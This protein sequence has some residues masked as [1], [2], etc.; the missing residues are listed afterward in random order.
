M[1]HV[2]H[3]VV[4]VGASMGGLRTAEALRRNGYEGPIEI[5]GAEI[6]E[7]YN[8]PPLSKEV[9]ASTVS[10]S[11]VNFTHNLL[12]ANTQWTLGTKVVN[13]DPVRHTVTDEFGAEHKY[14]ALVIATGLRPRRL[15]LDG[16]NA[17]GTHVLRTLDDAMALRK[18]LVP[19]A[20]VVIVGAGFIGCEVASTALALGCKV[21]VVAAD[22][23]PMIRPLGEKFAAELQRRHEA[24]GV[25]YFL[26]NGISEIVT[27]EGESELRV[28]GL[29]LNNGQTLDCQVLVQAIGSYPNTEW[30]A[31]SDLDISDG[32][33]TDNAM[34]ALNT[35]GEVVPDVYAVGDVARFPNPR[36]N[37]VP[38]RIEHWNIP[39]ETAK[40]VGQVLAAQLS[41]Q[42]TF[43]ERVA[44][45]FTPLPSFW[46][47][48]FGMNLLAFGD[49]GLANRSQL[50]DGEVTGDCIWGYFK[51]DVLVGVCGIGM[52]GALQSYRK[53]FLSE[54]PAGLTSGQI[55]S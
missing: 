31:E 28:T 12:D 20:E 47:D 52:R 3:P 13:A 25:T 54:L 39:I 41:H 19:G 22:A 29:K 21:A 42:Q 23:Y 10:H 33:L 43:D 36:F 49:L 38:R 50:L 4:I 51:D 11:A 5:I 17:L 6:Y 46:S 45:Q 27:S 40:R 37:A 18:D 14:A 32:V 44:Q 16:N 15:T 30:L 8:R 24:V 7:P 34:L 53:S 55:P 1:V 48:Q 35:M 26:N 9:L 2:T